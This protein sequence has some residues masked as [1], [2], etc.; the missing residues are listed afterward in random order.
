M[1]VT[2]KDIAKVYDEFG[3]DPHS[4]PSTFQSKVNA[5]AREIVKL[6]QNKK[7]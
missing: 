7:K 4:I 3:L 5:M 6:R 2:I 1:K